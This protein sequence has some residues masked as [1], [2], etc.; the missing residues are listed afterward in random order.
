MF[1]KKLLGFH[2]SGMEGTGSCSVI[3]F[4]DLRKHLVDEMCA[5]EPKLSELQCE[6]EILPTMTCKVRGYVKEPITHPCATSLRRSLIF[7][8]LGPS[9]MAPAV[10]EPPL[11]EGGPMLQ[12]F[13]KYSLKETKRLNPVFREA[14]IKDYFDNNISPYKSNGWERSIL[15][16]EEACKGVEGNRF[17]APLKRS[18]SS[19]YPYM[20]TQKKG[21]EGFFG[22]DDWDFSSEDCIELFKDCQRIEEQAKHG[23]VPEVIFVATLKD[24]KR[25]FNKIESKSTRVFSASP[26]HFTIVFR[27]YFA[28]FFSF[29][30]RNKIANE[31]AVGTNVHSSDWKGIVSHLQCST[32]T[33]L[34]AGDFKNFDGDLL[35]DIME[36]ILTIINDFYA[37]D[38]ADLRKALWECLTHSKQLIYDI[39]I[40]LY[41]GQPSGNPGT[42]IINSM[43]VS[44]LFRNAFYILMESERIPFS[45]ICKIVTY[46][47]DHILSVHPNFSSVYT[48]FD[49]KRCIEALG[50]GYTDAFKNVITEQTTWLGLHEV[51]FLKRSFVKHEKENYYYAPL[52][53]RSI[54]EMVNWIH[55]SASDLDATRLNCEG[56][57]RELCHHDKETFDLYSDLISKALAAHGASIKKLN[58]HLMR[59]QMRRGQFEQFV[60][61]APWV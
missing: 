56:A 19:G 25:T 30:M 14:A 2:Y 6:K 26:L 49:F 39:V 1:E 55:K 46:G 13:Q 43:Y 20:L 23:I 48:P 53:L 37:D 3:C 45:N 8:C 38:H 52:E 12:G 4:D 29:I 44:L 32:N 27:K 58:Y 16:Y 51:A 50:H 21:K 5:A 54:R 34:L 11:K 22:K 28:G 33:S 57:F 36:D 10:L 18:K 59:W 9:E 42:A 31:S 47:D 15:S 41:N 24:E 60:L 7:E 40:E 17:L 35:V 61:T